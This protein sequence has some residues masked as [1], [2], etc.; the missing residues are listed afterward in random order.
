MKANGLRERAIRDQ[1]RYSIV[2]YQTLACYMGHT[3]LRLHLIQ[4]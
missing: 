2:S 1:G 4:T 3:V